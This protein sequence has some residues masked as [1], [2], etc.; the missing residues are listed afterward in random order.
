M[1]TLA[2]RLGAVGI[3]AAGSPQV[4]DDAIR[5]LTLRATGNGWSLLG[6]RGEEVFHAPG[7]AG[8]RKCLEFARDHGVLVVL[9]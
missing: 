3:G 1:T 2:H 4:R 5:R 8:R 9:S 6:P 7:V